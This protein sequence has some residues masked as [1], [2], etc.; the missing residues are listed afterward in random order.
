[1]GFIFLGEM[2]LIIFIFVFYYVF[3][4]CDKFG[5][6]LEKSLSEVIVKYGVEDDD[7]MVNLIDNI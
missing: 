3:E 1:M 4:L 2:V 5:I 6:F 7:D